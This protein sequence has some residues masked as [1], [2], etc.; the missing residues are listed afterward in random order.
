M[1]TYGFCRNMWS[2]FLFVLSLF[3][4][5]A[6]STI[7][8]NQGN[9]WVYTHLTDT[10]IVTS[11]AGTNVSTDKNYKAGTLTLSINSVDNLHGGNYNLFKTIITSSGNLMTG[12]SLYGNSESDS[13]LWIE[14]I[15]MLDKINTSSNFFTDNVTANSNS[16][17]E[18]FMLVSYSGNPISVDAIQ[19]RKGNGNYSYQNS[20]SNTTGKILY[21]RDNLFV[22]NPSFCA[23]ST[24]AVKT[25]LFNFGSLHNIH[26]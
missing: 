14:N 22:S 25:S 19:S 1:S 23:L 6:A 8:I 4:V 20:H 16:Y 11:I 15:G 18:Q 5:S 17:L 12:H 2:A 3:G 13:I 24:N 9:K 26:R 10:S 21:L 7:P